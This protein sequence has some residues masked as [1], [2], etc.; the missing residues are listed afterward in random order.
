MNQQQFADFLG[1]SK[2]LL[3]MVESEVRDPSKE[4]ILKLSRKLKIHPSVIFSIRAMEEEYQ[5]TK[6]TRLEI[7]LMK[8][9][10][11]LQNFLIKKRAKEITQ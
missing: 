11:K 5:T 4:F 9:N 6:P 8:L 1:I 2:I 7:D 3:A 10:L